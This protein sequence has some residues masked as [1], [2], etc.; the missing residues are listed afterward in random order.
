[1]DSFDFDDKMISD[2][3]RRLS[4]TGLAFD[5]SNFSESELK[6]I[7]YLIE[8]SKIIDN[9]FMLQLCPELLEVKE[10]LEGKEDSKSKDELAYLLFNK[11]HLD[12]LDGQKPFIKGPGLCK[13]IAVYPE[14]ITKSELEG[15]IEKAEISAEGARSYYTSITRENGKLKVVN[16]SDRYKGELRK[17]A[18][19]IEKAADASDNQSL[20]D[21][22]KATAK[23]FLTNDYKDQQALWIKL[24]SRIEP[25]IGPYETYE[26]RI[27][28]YKG[29][30][31]S[32][33]NIRN[34]EETKKLQ[35][36]SKYLK[37]IDLSLPIKSEFKFTRK[38]QSTSPIVIADEIYF[39]GEAN[40]GFVTSA[41]NLPNDEAVRGAYGSKK[42]LMAN[43]TRNKFEKI[44]RPIAERLLDEEQLKYLDIGLATDFPLFHELSHGLGAAEIIE[45]DKKVSVSIKL[46]ELFSHIEEARADITGLYCADYFTSV[47][48]YEEAKMRRFYVNY[49]CMNILRG[50]RMGLK[51]AHAMGQA[52]KLQDYP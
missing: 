44:V 1:M 28:G 4:K 39:G 8:A 52:R 27:F 30:F 24:D 32:Y 47:G 50:I 3:F 19:S 42:V 21:Y 7:K 38:N 18:E 33:I 48:I 45:G 46:A 35:K 11:S 36:Y 12:A 40:A 51:E 22:L 49:L 14:G 15:A 37:E 25:T 10:G 41:F 43:I 26:D 29:F 17:A 23:A 2:G 16:Y 6:V 13:N 20:K 5:K 31:E 9:V 34:E